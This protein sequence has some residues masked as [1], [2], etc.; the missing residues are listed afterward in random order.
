MRPRALLALAVEAHSLLGGEHL[1]AAIR[2][3]AGVLANTI[4][5]H[6]SNWATV[7]KQSKV[8]SRVAH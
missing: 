1:A 4:A 7:C 6:G 2:A 5:A 3:A 8:G